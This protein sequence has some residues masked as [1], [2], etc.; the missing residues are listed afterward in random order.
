VARTRLIVLPQAISV[1]IPSLTNTVIGAF[2][3]TS[4]V[5]IVGIF[6]LLATTRMAYSDPAW[7]RHALEGL[8]AVGAFYLV[9]CW[10]ISRHSRALERHVAGWLVVR[11]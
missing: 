5:A 11:K 6:D 1:S 9:C 4:L 2:K 7:Q 10:S 8:V 3:D